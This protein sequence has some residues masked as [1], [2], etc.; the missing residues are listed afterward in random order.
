MQDIKIREQK[1]QEKR[2]NTSWRDFVKLA[3]RYPLNFYKKDNILT[4]YPNKERAW[5]II[6]P[7]DFVEIRDNNI[8]YWFN[9]NFQKD[10]FQNYQELFLKTPKPTLIQEQCEN[11]EYTEVSV[12][13]AKNSY[14]SFT[15]GMDTEN[16]FY[17]FYIKENCRN[18]IN[19]VM[20]RDSCDNIYMCTWIFKSFNVMDKDLND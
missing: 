20:V 5:Y 2:K 19:S 11:S 6:K 17:S 13:W 7:K 1:M 10:F 15:V 8:K 18:I 4:K 14:L 9:Y 3:S 12:F 16:V